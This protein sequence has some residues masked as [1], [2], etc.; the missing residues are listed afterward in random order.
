MRSGTA[1]MPSLSF[2]LLAIIQVGCA[3]PK[4]GLDG[5]LHNQ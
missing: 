2:S 5:T 1:F 4:E 3:Q